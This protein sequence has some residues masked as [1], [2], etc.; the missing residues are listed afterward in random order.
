MP[1]ST[2]VVTGVIGLLGALLTGAGE[3]ISHY[4]SLARF[5]TEYEF[6]IGISH[7]RS[8]VGHFRTVAQGIDPSPA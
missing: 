2:V 6:F 8:S 3:F 5:A 7:Q 4:D 1:K